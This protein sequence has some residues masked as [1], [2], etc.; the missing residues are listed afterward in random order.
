MD[1]LRFRIKN[2]GF[3]F[4]HLILAF[5]ILTVL[6][7]SATISSILYGRLNQTVNKQNEEFMHYA[8][9]QAL[10]G[11]ANIMESC[12]LI[13][14]DIYS[15]ST[16]ANLFLSAYGGNVDYTLFHQFI[17]INN[18]FENYVATN[19]DIR[20]ITIYKMDPELI[21]DGK[22]IRSIESFSRQDLMKKAIDAR[23]KN[24]WV[25]YEKEGGGTSILL[26]KYININLPGGILAIEMNLERLSNLYKGD[27]NAKYLMYLL[28]EGR[29]VF[30]SNPDIQLSPETLAGV[31]K[32][33]Q[34]DQVYSTLKQGQD[35]YYSYYGKVNGALTAVIL[36]DAYELGKEKR[37][38]AKYVL[39]CTL[40]FIL[41]GVA[42]AI[43]FSTRFASAIEKLAG[44][45]KAIEK[46]RLRLSPDRTYIREIAALDHTLCHM[47]QTIDGL[48]ADVAKTERQKVESEI[49]YLQMQ[50]NPHFL[51]NLLSAV[52]WMAFRK[53]EHKIV[54]II[55]LLSDFY[56]IALSQGK[57]L[58]AM[59]SEIQ[60]IEHYV[61]LQ[62][63]CLSDQIM[64]AVHVDPGLEDLAICKM[65]LQP[66]VENSI[67][68]GRIHGQALHIMVDIRQQEDRIAIMIQDDGMG[69]KESFGS[70]MESLNNGETSAIKVG[71]GVTN[72]FMRLKLYYRNARIHVRQGH[73]GTIVELSFSVG[74]HR[75]R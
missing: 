10:N 8:T 22:N 2:D 57:D 14:S 74:D 38:I 50:M 68:H 61:A 16:V 48:T 32:H 21:T 1:R 7:C 41:F 5:N 35:D 30:S 40:F 47:A 67:I 9:S 27:P 34:S 49:K 20:S 51:Y 42:L 59:K 58:I 60:L 62:N 44:K 26:L 71:Y 17:G 18:R 70:Y 53:S 54:Q 23:G 43:V 25:T 56:K 15:D 31:N 46:G 24:V 6:I 36:Y 52:R 33:M 19:I 69:A 11:L 72:T 73:P 55:D 12:E 28:S 39:I 4:F 65:T 64:L 37:S 63:C 45:M 29:T 3:K 75:V 13:A 66:F